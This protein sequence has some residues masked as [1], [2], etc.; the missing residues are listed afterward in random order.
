MMKARGAV[1]PEGWKMHDHDLQIRFHDMTFHDL[2]GRF[3]VAKLRRISSPPVLEGSVADAQASALA[4]LIDIFRLG[5]ESRN[6]ADLRAIDGFLQREFGISAQEEWE[7]YLQLI[8]R[9]HGDLDKIEPLLLTP[10]PGQPDQRI[11]IHKGEMDEKPYLVARIGD[12]LG[13][14]VAIWLN[15]PKEK[16]SALERLKDVFRLGN[17]GQAFRDFVE[18]ARKQGAVEADIR[19]QWMALEAAV[20]WETR[21]ERP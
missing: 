12:I 6:Y 7:A 5:T 1:E 14:P 3:L 13:S 8:R 16:E 9:N 4:R 2:E 17:R 11:V 15:F 21:G 10:Q 20:A 19:A 18:S